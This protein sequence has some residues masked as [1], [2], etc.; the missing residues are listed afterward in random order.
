MKDTSEKQR[1][2]FVFSL[3]NKVRSKE[4]L[5][6]TT[7]MTKKLEVKN[8]DQ[9]QKWKTQ[10]IMKQEMKVAATVSFLTIFTLNLI[11]H[12]ENKTACLDH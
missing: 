8:N 1:I 11:S 9:I 12:W 10:W 2:P 4:L 5:I 6:W 7:K 3:K